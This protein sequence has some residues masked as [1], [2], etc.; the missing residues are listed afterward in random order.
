MIA[1]RSSFSTLQLIDAKSGRAI[2]E[3]QPPH[4]ERLG[5]FCFN[6]TGDRLA[7]RY[8]TTDAIEIWDLRLIRSELAELGLDW[9]LPAFPPASQEPIAPISKVIVD[10]GEEGPH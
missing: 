2:A 10:A 9:P 7:V 8:G 3:L 4:E 5:Y 6:H 1:V